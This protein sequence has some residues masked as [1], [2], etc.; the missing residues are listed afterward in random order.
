[1]KKIKRFVFPFTVYKLIVN[2]QQQTTERT[3]I[4][5]CPSW[6]H[7]SL[8]RHS[9]TVNISRDVIVAASHVFFCFFLFSPVATTPITACSHASFTSRSGKSPCQI[10]IDVVA[11]RKHLMSLDKYVHC[12]YYTLC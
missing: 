9:L 1:M 2:H 10:Q 12:L 5:R 4:H 11:A 3:P 7:H 6:L 8:S